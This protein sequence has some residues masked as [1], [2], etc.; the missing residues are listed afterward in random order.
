MFNEIWQIRDYE[1]LNIDSFLI[2]NSYQRI[3]QRGGGVIIFVR[4]NIEYEKY[5]SPIIDGVIETTAIKVKNTVFMSLYRPP[6][7]NKQIFNEKLI[8]WI[9]STRDKNIYIA[10]DFNI[11]YLSNDKQYFDDIRNSTNLEP[12]ISRVT[13]VQSHTC[14]DN[15]LTNLE[16]YH[17]V[18]N[19]CIANHQGLRSTIKMAFEKRERKKYAYTEK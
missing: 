4:D 18:S 3:D 19:I 10:G 2:A 15:I 12:K 14:I 1:H 9:E 5:E 7:G 16:G 8:E 13:R 11:N 17:E 6:S